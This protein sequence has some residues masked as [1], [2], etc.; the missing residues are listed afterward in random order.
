M[1]RVRVSPEA[2]A[3]PRSGA[4]LAERSETVEREMR[5]I[6]RGRN[7]RATGARLAVLSQLHERREPMT[8][9]EVMAALGAG[10]FDRAT[11]WRILAVLAESGVLRRMDL[12]DRVWRYEL[13]DACRPL[14][15]DHAHFLCEACGAVSCLPQLEVRSVEGPLPSVLRG[16]DV[17]LRLTGRCGECTRMALEP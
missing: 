5:A 12:G 10:M 6:L 14:A 4:T 9:Q 11:V 8:H 13:L 1:V 2:P 16:A 17:R 3:G 15:D 7:L